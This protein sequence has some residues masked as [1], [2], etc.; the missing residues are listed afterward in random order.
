MLTVKKLIK[1]PIIYNKLT[2]YLQGNVI[3]LRLCDIYFLLT[4][5][6][7]IANNN[8]LFSFPSLLSTQFFIF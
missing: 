6:N 3:F 4:F 7:I 2:K 1:L 8:M 5:T